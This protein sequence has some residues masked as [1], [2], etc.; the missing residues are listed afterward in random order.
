MPGIVNR[1]LHRLK[2]YEAIRVARKGAAIL[3]SEGPASLLSDLRLR[4]RDRGQYRYEQ[5][6]RRN[7]VMPARLEEMK[8]EAES[9]RLRPLVSI[10]MPVYNVE[11]VWLEKAVESVRAQVYPEWELCIADD[12]ST[13]E[14]VGETLGRLA[15]L[16][17]CIKVT[18]L[19]ENEGI[20]GA[21]NAALG[22]ATGEYIGLLDNDDELAPEALFEVARLINEHP[23]ADMIYSDEDKLSVEGVRCEP[24]FKPEWSP[25]LILSHMYTCHFGVYRRSIAEAI[26]GFR[27]G[28]EGSQDYDFVLR[29]TEETSEVHHIPRVL[30]HWR[31][32]PGSTAASY[33][34][35]ASDDASLR[36][37]TEAAARR[38]GGTVERGMRLGTFRVRRPLEGK[39]LVSII[40]PT[41]NQLKMLSRCISSIR[42]KAAYRRYEI[43]VVDNNSAD[44]ETKS[45]LRSLAGQ[46]GCRVLP[47][48]APFNFAAINNMAA[49]EAAGEFLLFLNND[50]EM[51]SPESLGAML[52]MAQRPEVGA[53]GARLLFDDGTLQHAGIVLGVGGIA[54]HAFYRQPS[55][56]ISYYNQ[57]EV[58]RDCSAVT[59]ACLMTRRQL[60]LDIGGF[61]EANCPIAYN[62]VDLCLRLREEG[63][64]VVYTP[65]A[66]FYH[67]EMVSRG[68][69]KDPE[70]LY[71]KERWAGA[72][73]N[74]PYYS[75]NLSRQFFDFSPRLH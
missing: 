28:F 31:K 4:L 49:R 55:E 7:T 2:V 18:R 45:Y 46:E 67:H 23:A 33:D 74:D 44:P 5:W 26:G 65:Y 20:S 61:D 64:L 25:D 19:E 58:I 17:E 62:D 48:N 51:I 22:L 41:R 40:I 3:K 50:T 16:D 34:A 43:L 54:N 13:D 21:T 24:Y 30:Y 53:V 39:P 69:K 71:M 27:K 9:F 1:Y 36:A 57:A 29:F 70:A 72:L 35:K 75:P 68:N 42:E 15:R 14:R 12:A 37:L 56:G 6:L 38:F 8:R 32:I 59:G 66:Q 73:E 11:P 60:F 47:Y 52:E 63:Y 10:I